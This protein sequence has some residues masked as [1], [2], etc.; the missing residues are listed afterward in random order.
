ML[1]NWFSGSLAKLLLVAILAGSVLLRLGSAIYLGDEVVNMPGTNDQIS[2]HNLALRVLNGNGFSF[3]ESWWP[4]TQAGAPTAHWSFLYTFYLMVIYSLFGHHPLAAR[5]IQALIVG[6]L[7]PYLAYQIGQ[8]CL[9]K[10]AGLAAAGLTALYIYFI[11]YTGALMTE[12]FFITTVLAGLY[13][14]IRL[15]DEANLLKTGQVK[16]SRKIYSLA[17]GLGLVLGVA[18]LLRQLIMLFIPFLFIWIFLANPGKLFKPLAIA[19]TL[20]V[21]LILPFTIYNY[22]RFDRFVLLNTNS[23]YAFFFGNHPIYGTQF[24]PILESSTYYEMIPAELL[25]LDEAALDQALLKRGIQFV[26]DDPGR[27]VLLSI[28]RIPAFFMFWP[29]RDSG[30]ISNISRVGSFGLLLPLML[31]GLWL[32]VKFMRSPASRP[33]LALL[34]GFMFFYTVLHLLTWALIRYRLPVDAVLLIFAGL[35]LADLLQRLARPIFNKSSIQNTNPV[36]PQ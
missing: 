11:Y 22:T 32:S 9:N 6:I 5:L 25:S 33:A 36:Q 8:R 24:Q 26:V 21:I 12:P 16:A 35:G 7:Q 1:V 17:I 20:T 18:V 28:S 23:G 2:Y 4:A 29:S 34:Y 30:L 27:Y 3:G 15:V 13:L 31:Y 19:G 14:S 10:P